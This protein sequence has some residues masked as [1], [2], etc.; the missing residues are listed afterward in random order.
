MEDDRKIADLTNEEFMNLIDGIVIH[1]FNEWGKGI[2]NDAD[3]TRIEEKL[4]EAWKL[5]TNAPLIKT[6]ATF[7]AGFRAGFEV[8]QSIDEAAKEEDTTAK[9][10][11]PASGQDRQSQ[12]G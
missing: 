1:K 4:A 8:A 6:A 5:P 9:E 12:Q 11:G 7:Y 10:E 2:P 3:V